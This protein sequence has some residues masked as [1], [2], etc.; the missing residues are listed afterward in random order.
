MLL[1]LVFGVADLVVHI[2]FARCMWWLAQYIDLLSIEFDIS[3]P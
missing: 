3:R 1:M 2:V